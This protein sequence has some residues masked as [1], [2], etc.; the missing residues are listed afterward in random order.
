MGLC[1]DPLEPDSAVDD[2]NDDASTTSSP[3]RASGNTRSK[4]PRPNRATAKKPIYGHV[5]GVLRGPNSEHRE[6]DCRL[7]TRV[8]YVT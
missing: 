8:L 4:K 2:N 5:N 1:S 3:D 6:Y 7:A